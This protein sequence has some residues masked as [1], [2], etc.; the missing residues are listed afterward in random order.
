MENKTKLFKSCSTS[1]GVS[2]LCSVAGWSIDMG[3]RKLY[4]RV[5]E[6]EHSVSHR[7]NYLQWR[8]TER[9][10]AVSSGVDMQLEKEQKCKNGEK[11]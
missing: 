6:H 5:P 4:D 1:V 11:F 10:L 9:R 7:Q 8:T 3:W 2:A